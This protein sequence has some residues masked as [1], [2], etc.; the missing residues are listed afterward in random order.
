M[1]SEA[2]ILSTCMTMAKMVEA[3]VYFHYET[4]ESSEN[5]G[6][7]KVSLNGDEDCAVWLPKKEINIHF[8]RVG[9]RLV[10]V[11]EWLW[12]KKFD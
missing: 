4:E 11:P 6:A 5:A 2:S 1:Q 3:E 12:I 9:R 7:I 10:Q 8:T